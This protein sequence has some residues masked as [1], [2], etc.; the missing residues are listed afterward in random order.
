LKS[1]RW[2]GLPMQSLG[3]RLS[4]DVFSFAR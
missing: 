2:S 1:A 4:A 3:F